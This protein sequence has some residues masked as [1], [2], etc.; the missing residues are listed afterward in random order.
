MKSSNNINYTSN[1]QT[2]KYKK[3]LILQNKNKNFE[4][5]FT[6]HLES[7]VFLLIFA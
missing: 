6:I 3:N 7:V 1:F 2:S 5:M 4:E